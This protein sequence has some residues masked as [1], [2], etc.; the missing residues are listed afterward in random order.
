MCENNRFPHCG[1]QLQDVARASSTRSTVRSRF[2]SMP[3]WSQSPRSSAPVLVFLCHLSTLN[4]HLEAIIGSTCEDQRQGLFSWWTHSFFHL[5]ISGLNI[6]W[7]PT[8]LD[9]AHAVNFEAGASWARSWTFLVEQNMHTVHMWLDTSVYQD[10]CTQAALTVF[11]QQCASRQFVTW[12]CAPHLPE[13]HRR[14]R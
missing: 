12:Q 2:P 5:V 3:A 4:S 14:L 6:R 13:G 1:L 9:L 10:L 11:P 8:P 7:V